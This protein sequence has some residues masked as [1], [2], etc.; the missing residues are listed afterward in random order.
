MNRAEL[1]GLDRERLVARAEEAG[2]ARA[3]TLTRPEIID[4]LLMRAHGRTTPAARRARGFFGLARDLLASV[5]ERGLHLPD[6]ADR[7]RSLGEDAPGG[8]PPRAPAALPTMTLAEIYAA[9]GHRDRA[10]E[11]LEQVL[12]REPEHVAARVLYTQL[13]DKDYVSPR[14]PLPPEP[15]GFDEPSESSLDELPHEPASVREPSALDLELA[16]FLGRDVDEPATPETVDA[17]A[18]TG[19]GPARE[20]RPAEVEPS[21]PEPAP[22]A[23]PEPPRAAPQPDL[24]E[25]R[26]VGD[27]AW[28]VRFR[29]AP[30]TLV[31]L[32]ERH[33]ISGLTLRAV[34]VFAGWDGPMR[35][36]HD[37]ALEAPE[38]ELRLDAKGAASFR[39]AVGAIVDGEFASIAHA[40]WLELRAGRQEEVR[41]TPRGLAR[42][43]SAQHRST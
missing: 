18:P 42:G 14:E 7:I 38:G 37:V 24:C 15:E 28:D 26:P 13:T 11:T 39:V 9:Q 40:P 27:G 2:V 23:S 8:E 21:A 16:R 1:E 25:A 4:E 34:H 41:W 12:E 5:V 35:E 43:P 3:R 19:A 33:E 6:A 30:E 17:R 10:I 31:F 32:A 29:V 36:V 22:H 20:P